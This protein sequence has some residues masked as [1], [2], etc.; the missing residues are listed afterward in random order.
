MHTS[1]HVCVRVHK[2]KYVIVSV[3]VLAGLTRI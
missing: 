2:N 3:C 1:V